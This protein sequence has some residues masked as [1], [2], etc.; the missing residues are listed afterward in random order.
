[1]SS[2]S[3]FWFLL[4]DYATCQH[5]EA[6]MA[7]F[8]S[9][10]PGSLVAEFRDAVL[11]KNPN[12]L[13]RFDASDLVV[14]KNKASFDKRNN[15][16]E[17]EGKEEALDPTQSVD[18]LGSKEDMLVV[19]VPSPRSSSQTTTDLCKK[20]EPN[21]KRK[22]RWIELNEIL[23]GNAKKSKANG[24][25]AYSYVT[26]SQVESVFAPLNYVQAKRAMDDTQ[27]DFLEKYLS[28][29]T[30]CFGAI[31]TGKEAKR[32]HFIAPILVCVCF[33]L[34]GDVKIVAEEDLVG[35]FVKAHGHFEFMLIRGTKAVCIVEAKKDDIEQGLAQDLIGCEVA[36]ELG[37]L[38]V[39]YGIVTNYIQWIFFCSRNDKVEI[40][41]SS[42][43]LSPNGPERESLKEVAEKI[44]SMLADE[45]TQTD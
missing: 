10:P 18:G 42:L 4:L 14:Y 44:Y 27:L 22:Q 17:D 3:K 30:K 38:D 32:L 23:D 2:S 33:L 21:Q 26:W 39:V 29:T 35:N 8:V 9:L 13:A 20:K 11:S 24:S 6:S 16:A 31:T 12:K 7:D 1:M 43:R 40:D 28:F 34:K 45:D 36:A 19:V 15:A 25:T 41:E 5:Y 37:G